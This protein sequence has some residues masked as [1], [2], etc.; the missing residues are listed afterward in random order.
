VLSK[1]R[2]HVNERVSHLPR[3]R[4]RATMPAIGPKSPAAPNESVHVESNADGEAAN[5]G[6]QSFMVARFDDEMHVIPLHGKVEDSEA[7]WR[8]PSGASQS[9]ANGREHVLAA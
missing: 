5:T 3:R 7:L 9:E 4:E 2:E 1:I 6:G 8:A